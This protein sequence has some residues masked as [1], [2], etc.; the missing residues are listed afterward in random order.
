M[1]VVAEVIYRV[2]TFFALSITGTAMGDHSPVVRSVSWEKNVLVADMDDSDRLMGVTRGGSSLDESVMLFSYTRIF[3]SGRFIRHSKFMLSQPHQPRN[4]IPQNGNFDFLVGIVCVVGMKAY[5]EE[6]RDGYPVPPLQDILVD[7][8]LQ[9]I[10]PE[11]R[12]GEVRDLRGGGELIPGGGLRY[13]FGSL[14]IVYRQGSVGV[15]ED[16]INGSR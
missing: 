7:I 11:I 10:M 13:L 16:H 6:F 8:E 15:L 9:R 2:N 1:W 14:P 4:L 3:S 5:Q 12:I